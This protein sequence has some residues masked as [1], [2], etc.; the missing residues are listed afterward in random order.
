MARTARAGRPARRR[1]EPAE[2]CP[3][4]WVAAGLALLSVLLYLNTLG[5]DFVFDDVT[6]ILQNP[7]IRSLDW[8]GIVVDSGYRPVRTL[9]YAFNYLIGGENPFSY[10]LF[11]VLLHAL[12]VVVLYRLLWWLS[13]GSG[14]AAGLGS[15]FFALHPVQTAAVAY[16]SGRKDLLAA[17]F[18]MLALVFYQ[19]FRERAGKIYRAGAAA[20]GCFFLALFS[21]EVAI[22]FP[23]L[24]LL[25]EALREQYRTSRESGGPVSL[26]RAGSAAIR[27]APVLYGIF[28]LLAVVG[29]FYALFVAKASRM[30]GYWG[31]S[32]E[33][34]LGTGCKLFVHYLKMVLVPYPM[35]ADYL[36]GVFPVSTGLLEPAT[37]AA[38]LLMVGYGVVAVW[39]FRKLPL[40]SVGMLW[41][42]VSIAP[43]LQFIPFHELAADHFLYV[44]MIG[45]A[46]ALS[47]VLVRL[48]GRRQQ[49]VAMT[50]L[51]ITAVVYGAMVIDRN[52]DWKDKQTIWEA[53]LRMA[54]DS[55]RANA[56]LGQVY[57]NSGRYEEG[58]RLTRRSA[59]LAPDRALPYSNLGAMYYTMAQRA[60]QSGDTARAEQLQFEAQGYFKKALELETDNPFTYSNLG[61][62]YKEQALLLDAKGRTDEA[63]EARLQAADLYKRAL[64]I[65]DRRLDVQRIWFN[66]G[67][68]YVD[69]GSYSEG[70]DYLR[71]YLSQFPAD[72]GGSYWMGFALL[73]LGEY[74]RAIPLFKTALQAK[75]TVEA[76]QQLALAYQESGREAE[77]AEAYQQLV[78]RSP[79]AQ[80]FYNLGQSL[81]RVG[82]QSQA[83]AAFER[84]LEL[85]PWGQW[86]A[87]SRDALR[88][89]RWPRVELIK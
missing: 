63:A 84:V 9:T 18:M 47:G 8:W 85:D 43:V 86:G 1:Q 68:L 65:P 33:A 50:V 15:L 74:D 76:W 38:G 61:N 3:N 57:F 40:V 7:Q 19:S 78:N 29:L 16:I 10:H 45:G 59:E 20:A 56:N 73:K 82:R 31:G 67:L 53:T 34:N 49:T 48:T 79:T 30:E 80:N 22:V 2:L 72:P 64:A 14:F 13:A 75:Q 27:S 81:L 28:A 12:N 35:L 6:L 54:P 5:H 88:S 32:L 51:M 24:L 66:F 23:V 69:A 70:L 60:R 41:F 58:I 55:Y 77:A 44:P 37:I 71:R 42:A 4:Y 25:V 62:T 17:L 36:G 39:L 87:K 83:R 11:S 52:S 89:P 46:L 26:I 21:K